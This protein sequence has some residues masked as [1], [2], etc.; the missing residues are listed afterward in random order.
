MQTGRDVQMIEGLHVALLFF[1]VLILYPRVQENKP[2]FLDLA[3]RL[4]TNHLLMQ[5]LRSCGYKH[6]S[7]S[8]ESLTLWLQDYGVTTWVQFTFRL[9]QFF[10][11]ELS[12]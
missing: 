8:W 11:Q 10:M 6:Y 2:L 9:I 12:I 7:L 5:Q 4:N 3:Q 1:L